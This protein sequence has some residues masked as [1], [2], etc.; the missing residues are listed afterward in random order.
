MG[1]K[2]FTHSKNLLIFG[3]I[4]IAFFVLPHETRAFGHPDS[5]SLEVRFVNPNEGEALKPGFTVRVDIKD[6]TLDDVGGEPQFRLLFTKNGEENWMGRGGFTGSETLINQEWCSSEGTNTCGVRIRAA[7]DGGRITQTERFFTIDKTPPLITISSNQSDPTQ[8]TD[9][10]FKFSASDAYGIARTQCSLDGTPLVDCASPKSY[11]NIFPDGIHAFKVR[12]YDKAENF[13]EKTLSWQIDSTPPTRIPGLLA[14]GPTYFSSILKWTAP[15]EFSRILGRAISASQYDVRYSVSPITEESWGDATALAYRE[16][17]IVPPKSPGSPETLALGPTRIPQD[18]E[19]PRSLGHLSGFN[20]LSANTKHYFAIKSRDLNWNW[21]RL[22]DIPSLWTLRDPCD[23][24]ADRLYS[25]REGCGPRNCDPGSQTCDLYDNPHEWGLP[26]DWPFDKPDDFWIKTFGATTYDLD[27]DGEDVADGRIGTNLNT[28]KDVI[29]YQESGGTDWYDNPFTLDI[30]KLSIKPTLAQF[31]NTVNDLDLDTFVSQGWKNVFGGETLT[32]PDTTDIN[33]RVYPG[34]RESTCFD[35][36]AYNPDLST[37]RIPPGKTKPT[38]NKNRAVGQIEV[39]YTDLGTENYETIK[40][41]TIDPRRPVIAASAQ[42]RDGLNNDL[43]SG[44][45]SSDNP[46]DPAR[47]INCPTKFQIGGGEAGRPTSK[48]EVRPKNNLTAAIFPD[49]GLVQCGRHADDLE[50]EIVEST[51]CNICHFLYLVFT[52]KNLVI[53]R[54]MPFV[55]ALSIV[56]GGFL[57]VISRGSVERYKQGRKVIVWAISAYAATLLAW[58]LISIFFTLIGTTK[59]TG[60]TPEE[61]EIS[62]GWWSFTCKLGEVAIADFSTS[63]DSGVAPFEVRFTDL[64]LG[65]NITFWNWDFGD[66]G[67]SSEQ[68]PKHAYTTNGPHSATLTVL[69]K[70]G[71]TGKKTKT[72]HYAPTADFSANKTPGRS[73]L[74]IQFTDKSTG[75]IEKWSWDFDG[76]NREDSQNKDPLYTYTVPGPYRAKLTVS[77]PGGRDTASKLN[78]IFAYP[79]PLAP[80]ANFATSTYPGEFLKLKTQNLS[81][82]VTPSPAEDHITGWEWDFGDGLGKSAVE[83]PAYFYGTRAEPYTLMLKAIGPGGENSTSTTVAFPT[84]ANFQASPTSGALPAFG[85]FTT[86]LQDNST[87][88]VNGWGWNFGDGGVGNLQSPTHDYQTNGLY[89]VKLKASGPEGENIKI[90]EK[91]IGVA[92]YADFDFSCISPNC[93]VGA[94]GA[95]TTLSPTGTRCSGDCR[96]YW[97]F[98]DGATKETSG[99]IPVSHIYASNEIYT[100]RLTVTGPGGSNTME[101]KAY[102]RVSPYAEF[103]VKSAP[104]GNISTNGAT[105]TGKGSGAVTFSNNSRVNIPSSGWLWEFGDGKTS[106]GQEATHTYSA[107]DACYSP[108]LTATGPGGLDTETKEKYITFAPVANI[109]PQAS[110]VEEDLG[111]VTIGCGESPPPLY[112]CVSQ[113]FTN[114]SDPEVSRSGQSWESV[115]SGGDGS[116]TSPVRTFC[117]NGGAQTATLTVTNKCDPSQNDSASATVNIII[118]QEVIQEPCP[119]PP[120]EELAGRQETLQAVQDIIQNVFER[121]NEFSSRDI[122]DRIAEAFSNWFESIFGK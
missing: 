11:L 12:A 3:A 45:D 98:G 22:S 57:M 68:S 55:V 60:L 79:A 46:A 114:L 111:T 116:P 85:P 48:N 99:V 2:S 16:H 66:G 15:E 50:T 103:A 14:I 80:A 51:N 106:N 30:L 6:S 70:D 27:L 84:Q 78:Y 121:V 62:G 8:K 67:T 108:K 23:Y 7:D 26:G 35:C 93:T 89:T 29:N 75:E 113:T 9:V 105:F 77:G 109:E 42:C 49:V 54:L 74:K 97:E 52:V 104:E 94:S 24:D 1:G 41:G 88:T 61:G 122:A 53:S 95:D 100:A 63:P 31:A 87:G 18:L 102:I 107:I 38:T 83:S 59:W 34:A 20:L 72:I 120:A 92:P 39:Y 96:A 65:E 10:E 43:L 40:Q 13:S 119:P 37:G 21:S 71:S 76:D 81:F 32:E 91:Y 82:D 69:G 28:K 73:P 17:E 33:G 4:I 5:T 110:T 112:A 118:K 115:W 44:T 86:R 47:E 58:T 64:S 36:T 25:P 90:I 56:A 101:K 117:G 19:E